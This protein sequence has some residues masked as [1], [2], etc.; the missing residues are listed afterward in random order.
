[1]L[2]SL[3]CFRAWPTSE[4]TLDTFQVAQ[5]DVPTLEDV[6]FIESAVDNNNVYLGEA[7]TLTLIY[8][9]L[10]FRGIRVEDY[11]KSSRLRLPDTEGF[12]AE[13]PV[14][15]KRTMSRDGRNYRVTSHQIRL[16]PTRTGELF[17]GSWRWR[18]TARG[19]TGTGASAVAIDKRTEPLRIMVKALPPAPAEFDGAVGRFE[20]AASIDEAKLIQGVPTQLHIQIQGEG[21]S[22]SIRAPKIPPMPWNRLRDVGASSDVDT[23]THVGR[24][25]RDFEFELVPVLDGFFELGPISFTYFSPATD[26][27]ET[28]VAPALAVTVEANGMNERL[29]VVGGISRGESGGLEVM[30]DGRLPLVAETGPMRRV[31]HWGN[32]MSVLTVAPMGVF[33]LFLLVDWLRVRQEARPTLDTRMGRL[34]EAMTSPQPVDRLRA[35][36]LNEVASLTGLRTIGMTAPDLEVVLLAGAWGEASKHVCAALRQCDSYRY[37]GGEP[38]LQDLEAIVALAGSALDGMGSGS[39]S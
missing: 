16:F 36:I 28:A 26:R 9:Q 22:Q 15:E 37:G 14:E 23:A 31:Q 38:A 6:V 27:Y 11:Y 21:N 18:G 2:L 34:H 20:I 29:V 32:W 24:F 4:S 5:A 25:S 30:N 7:V 3:V 19:Y 10:D 17:I 13:K 1:M 8:G 35:V 33:L 12:F 39:G